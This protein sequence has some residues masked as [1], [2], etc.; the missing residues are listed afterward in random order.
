M[1]NL[2]ISNLAHEFS[3]N[4]CHTIKLKK[5]LELRSPNNLLRSFNTILPTIS[6]GSVTLVDQIVLLCIDELVNPNTVLEIG[7]FQGFTTRLLA[8]NSSASKIYSLDLPPLKNNFID[9]PVLDKVL[10]NGD[11]NDD[12]LRDMQ[13]LS[14]EIYLNDL[15]NKFSNKIQLIK[16]DSTKLNF[17]KSIKECEFAFIDGGHSYDIVKSDTE[18]VKKIMSKGVIIWHDYAS[19]IHSDVIKY[20]N[21]YALNNKIFHISGSLCAFQ[22][23]GV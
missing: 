12:Y 20:L 21:E 18:N 14:G 10:I 17:E 5:L 7:T 16:H 8:T 22:I 19:G 3:T 9:S 1:T 13:N 11:Y 6:I 2:R 4:G 15:E 23:I